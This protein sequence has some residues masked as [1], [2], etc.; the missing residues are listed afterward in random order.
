[1]AFT[2]GQGVDVVYDS[3]GSTLLDSFEVAK[4]KGTVVFF[5]A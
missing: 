2:N 1:L 4:E 5:M 3:V